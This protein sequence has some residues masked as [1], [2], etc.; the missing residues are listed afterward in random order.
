[1]C[2]IPKPFLLSCAFLDALKL[3]YGVKSLDM[4]TL[5]CL[6]TYI[7]MVAVLQG[8]DESRRAMV[9]DVDN[10]FFYDLPDLLDP[11]LTRIKESGMGGCLDGVTMYDYT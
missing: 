2:P 9:L 5:A 10:D 6:K 11:L 8:A 1:M 7:T 3:T 4:V